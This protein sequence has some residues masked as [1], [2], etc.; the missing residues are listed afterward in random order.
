MSERV[1]V[2]PG[3]LGLTGDVNGSAAVEVGAPGAGLCAA[4]RCTC[5]RFSGGL[6]SG[7]RRPEAG[8]PARA[9]TQCTRRDVC[10]TARRAGRGRGGTVVEVHSG[11]DPKKEES[12][13]S[14]HGGLLVLN[15]RTMKTEQSS[16]RHRPGILAPAAE[17][18]VACVAI[19]RCTITSA[20]NTRC[21]ANTGEWGMAGSYS[22]P[23]TAR[24]AAGDCDLVF[25]FLFSR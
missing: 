16:A 20:G 12:R 5:T 15:C 25:A 22:M 4:V 19:L 7:A 8:Q 1:K 23:P 6:V 10:A 9:W 21:N 17:A 13:G 3:L 18:W 2:S 24:P 11:G 14:P